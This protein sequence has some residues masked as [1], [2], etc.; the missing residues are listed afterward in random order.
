MADGDS[1]IGTP[2]FK[3]SLNLNSKKLKTVP[4]CVSGLTTLSVLLLSYNSITDLPAEMISLQQLA[5]LNLGNNALKELPAVLGHLE[6][7]KKL[8]LFRNQIAVVPSDAIGGLRNLVV[9]NLNHN[10]IQRLPAEMRSLRNLEHLS[11]L[12]NKLEEIPV[13][14]GHLT[15]LTEINLTSNKLSC[16]PQ[17]LYCCRELRKLYVA[18]NKLTSLPEGITALAKL[19]VLDVAGNKL[20]MFPV[21]FHLLPLKELHCE[22]NKFVQC[23]PVPSL[24]YSV[25]T[26]KELVARFILQ[27]NRDRSSLIHMTLPHYPSL[28]SL[29]DSSSYCALCH[30]PVFSTWLNCV[31]F[32]NLKR[33]MNIRCSLTIPVR[34]LLCSQKCFNAGGYS[35]C[36]VGTR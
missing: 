17:Q 36:G 19:Q 16:L 5:E 7:L 34:A 26:L 9:L 24:P 15:K 6:S 22:G 25:L 23:E 8:Y 33:D 18:R 21:E 29:L 13:E 31:H 10:K 35:Y 20:S 11:V 2:L 32:I 4:T 3:N 27:E 12:D 14:L 1:H 30:T 28:N